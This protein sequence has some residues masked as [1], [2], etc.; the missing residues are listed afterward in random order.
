VPWKN[1]KTKAA[2]FSP[3]GADITSDG[4]VWAVLASGD[5]ASFDRRLCKGPLKGAALADPQ[6]LCPE[7]WKITP[8]PGPAFEGLQPGQPGAVAEAP[9]Y[10]WVDQYDTSGL[11]K[12]TPIATG[13]ESDSLS[14]LV[15]GKWVVMRVPYPLG[16]FAKGMDGRIDDANAG[17]KGKGLW[18]AFSNPRAHP[19]RRRQR[20]DQ[21]GRPFPDQAKSDRKLGRRD[22]NSARIDPADL[23]R[24]WDMRQRSWA[25]ENLADWKRASA[26]RS[27]CPAGEKPNSVLDQLYRAVRLARSVTGA[28]LRGR[29]SLN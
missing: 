16:Y 19:H 2:G 21:Q 6:N 4:V 27:P 9:Y 18:S 29:T 15:N 26:W 3:R 17:W 23:R 13:N 28:R 1:A 22:W 24:A 25:C 5:L 8:M 11:G 20:P 10:D 12:N 14:A 7:G